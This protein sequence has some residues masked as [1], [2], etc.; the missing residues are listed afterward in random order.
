MGERERAHGFSGLG[1]VDCAV[2]CN[3]AARS[4]VAS[5]RS[6][7]VNAEDAEE[8]VTSCLAP[9][10]EHDADPGTSRLAKSIVL[11]S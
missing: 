1:S 11:S 6:P 7:G 2:C 3:K 10:P 9:L 8:G 4:Q 5:P